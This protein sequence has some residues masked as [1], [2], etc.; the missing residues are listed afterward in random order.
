[1]NPE[2]PV[3][4]VS[5]PSR[6]RRALLV[7]TFAL[8]VVCA[9]LAAW[10]FLVGRWHETTDDAYVAGNVVQ[11]TPQIASTVTA[12]YADDT[13]TVAAGAVLVELDRADARVTLDQA[14]AAL[15]Q[16]VREVRTLY[17]TGGSLTAVVAQ[18]ETDLARAK[19]DLRRRQDLG[20]SG[21]VSHEELDHARNTLKAAEAAVATSREQLASNRVLTDRTTVANHPNVARAA[22]QLEQ[23]YLTYRRT[24]ITAPLAGQVAKRGVQVGARVAPGQALMAIVPLDSLWVEANF[25][26]GQLRNMRIG[27]SVDLTADTYGS[28][29][30]YVGKVIGVGAGTGSAFALLPAQNATGNWIKIVQRL[31]VRI[32]LDAKQ[33]AEHP[34]RVGLSLQV[35]VDVHEVDGAPLNAAATQPRAPL[36]SRTADDGQKEAEQLIKQIVAANLGDVPARH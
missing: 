10:W 34:L 5:A 26:E 3:V 27:Q 30:H 35:D 33:V 31:P 15:A 8:I 6:R 7:L 19:E 36:L 23:A 21:A 25:K 16:T 29:V 28:G 13:D 18:R 2:T 9:G 24:T 20:S 1:M 22:A 17:A 11:I 4:A 12:I 32:A 14:K